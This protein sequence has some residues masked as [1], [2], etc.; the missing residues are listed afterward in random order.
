MTVDDDANTAQ[1]PASGIGKNLTL[2][3]YCFFLFIRAGGV[4]DDV[5][6]VGIHDRQCCLPR[7]AVPSKGHCL[8]CLFVCYFVLINK[9]FTKIYIN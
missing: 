4:C 9:I 3:I 7:S 2:Y 1:C 5:D 8:L 6:D